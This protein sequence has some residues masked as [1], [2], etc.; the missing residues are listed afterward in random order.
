MKINAEPLFHVK[1]KTL[2]QLIAN[3]TFPIP[4]NLNFSL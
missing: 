3:M 2:Y 4:L 1:Q